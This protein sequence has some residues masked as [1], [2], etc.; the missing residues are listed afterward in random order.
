MISLKTTPSSTDSAPRRI[1]SIPHG[2]DAPPTVG[3]MFVVNSPQDP[4]RSTSDGAAD[5]WRRFSGFVSQDLHTLHY[6][7]SLD[8]R[9]LWQPAFFSLVLPS[10]VEP[11]ETAAEAP[12]ASDMHAALRDLDGAAEEAAEEGFPRPSLVALTNARRLLQDLYRLRPSR[13]E[14]YPTPDGEVALVVPGGHGRSVLVLC[15]SLG[16]VLCS[17]N[18]NGR[19]RRARYETATMLPDGFVREAV[20]ELD[21]PDQTW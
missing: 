3:E 6:V 8:V 19:H 11:V 18:L 20:T 21:A 15:D 7:S 14:A 9:R 2:S 10:E 12:R 5:F 1:T 13:L 16:G 17:V 4:R